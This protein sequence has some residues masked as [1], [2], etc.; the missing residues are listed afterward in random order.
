MKN[1]R[2]W[3]PLFG[4]QFM[5]VLN[6]N[7]LKSLI[8]FVSVLWLAEPGQE[9]IVVTIA[10][11]LLVLPYLVFS[12][13]A[14][15]ITS[16]GSKK[17]IVVWAKFFEL[18]IMA[19]AILGFVFQSI[20][21]V[22]TALFLM[23]FQSAMYSPAKY[24]LIRDIGGLKGVSF[25][26]GTMELLS[27]VALLMGT[28][29]AGIVS[30]LPNVLVIMSVILMGLALIGWFSSAKI[31]AVEDEPETDSKESINPIRFLADSF[32][33]SKK[34]K[35]LN[36]TI[37]G[38]SAFWMI[39]SM[40]QMNLIVHLPNAMGFSNSETSIVISLVAVGIGVGCWLAGVLA[41]NRVEI[42]MVPLGGLGM[43]TCLSIL[44]FGNLSQTPFIIVLVL[45]AMCGGFFKVPLTAWIQQRVKGR[46]LSQILAYSNMAVFMSILISA[47]LFGFLE[48]HFDTMAIFKTMALVGLVASVVTFVRVPSLVLRFVFYIVARS[49]YRVKVRGLS[50]VPHDKGALVIANHVSFLDSFLLVAAV[51]RTFRFVV[52]SSVYHHKLLHWAFKRLHMI[53]IDPKGTVQDLK[54]FNK[55]CQEQVNQ[56]H[57]VVIFAEGTISRTGHLLG[58]KRGMEHIAKG[59]NAPI[60]PI[61][62]DG[63]HGSPMTYEAGESKMVGM[64]PSRW[65]RKVSI[66]IGE[67]LN[68]DI[69]AFEARQV[70]SELNSES[71][72][73]RIEAGQT[74]GASFIKTARNNAYKPF[75]VNG[76]EEP[77]SFGEAL[78]QSLELALTWKKQLRSEREIVLILPQQTQASLVNLSLTMAGKTVININ[79]TATD[80]QIAEVLAQCKGK[81]VI[82]SR[83]FI[84]LTKAIDQNDLIFIEDVLNNISWMRRITAKTLSHFGTIEQ[85]HRFLAGRNISAKSTAAITFERDAFSGKYY[86]IKLTHQNI[87]ANHK[88]LRQVY[89]LTSGDSMLGIMPFGRSFGY[90]SHLWMPA[91]AGMKVVYPYHRDDVDVYADLILTHEVNI[92]AGSNNLI[93][94]M[95]LTQS[96]AIWMQLKHVITGNRI[97]PE[98]KLALRTNF[99][100]TPKESFGF[101]ETT[102]VI[103]VN[104]PDYVGKDIAGKDIRQIGSLENRVGRPLPGVHI[105]V[106]DPCDYDREL[107]AEEIGLIMVKGPNVAAGYYGENTG[108]NGRFHEEWF[109]TGERGFI[110]DHGFVGL[111]V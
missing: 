34:V 101:P 18:P 108:S 68:S 79:T 77:I 81:T 21:I 67:P 62:M 97:D 111:A 74:L 44:A 66:N 2:K 60:L 46:K 100:L 103:A 59:I 63:V 64:S 47:L 51:P 12:P 17:K 83:N 14:S 93:E 87:L 19:I 9:S 99:G 33:W 49:L 40:L 85:V 41:R 35:G 57:I 36:M 107:S 94:L 54:A 98:V 109:V 31:T 88:G 4:T 91:L 70:H 48:T 89:G 65:R 61:H 71:F 78:Q 104:T 43:S 75:A 53:P 106:V 16:R 15:R 24:A 84:T 23:G 6:D 86:G 96:K 38:L 72:E 28:V 22:L 80:A 26:T 30:D 13:L 82:A 10:T 8:C 1:L 90:C 73:G 25:G 45:G 69:K 95:Y 102:S 37:L 105:K 110:D 39:A 7:F 3:I 32:K 11:G 20:P 56:G 55:R 76:N 52:H 50:N 42:G 5:G 92:L 27:F 58:F 29:L